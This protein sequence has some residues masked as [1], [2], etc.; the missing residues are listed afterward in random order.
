[1][2]SLHL[3]D[4]TVHAT[5]L[6][7]PPALSSSRHFFHSSCSPSSALSNIGVRFSAPLLLPPLHR[8]CRHSPHCV[9]G[10]SPPLMSSWRSHFN[11]EGVR[12]SER[13]LAHTLTSSPTTECTSSWPR[14]CNARYE[15]RPPLSR[16]VTAMRRSCRT[17]STVSP[18]RRRRS[19]PTRRTSHS[20]P[21]N[22]TTSTL[23]SAT[24]LL[25]SY[26]PVS[27]SLSNS[28]IFSASWTRSSSTPSSPTRICTP[29]LARQSIGSLSP[30]RRCGGT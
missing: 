13:S 8:L 7:S 30:P 14:T 19:L 28:T 16:P 18:R 4:D 10:C 27:T 11:R 20:G 9:T 26:C 6:Y 12:G 15:R 22:S 23:P 21:R 3:V 1:M 5:S 17:P 24:P 29:S 2:S 25:R